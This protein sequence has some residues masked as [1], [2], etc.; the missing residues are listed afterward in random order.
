VVT[1]SFT[2]ERVLIAGVPAKVVKPLDEDSMALVTY[3]TRPGLET[4]R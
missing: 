4:A 3:P 2:E 1:R